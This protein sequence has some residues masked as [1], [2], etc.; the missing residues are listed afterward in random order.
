MFFCLQEIEIEVNAYYD[1][2]IP[3]G[4]EHFLLLHQLR[5][6]ELCF[7]VL[8]NAV[9]TGDADLSLCFGRERRGKGRRQ[10][11]VMDTA[12]KELRHR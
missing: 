10:A 3:K 1:E 6:I 9:A 4:S 8:C 11:M 12:A 2:L 7:D 5:K